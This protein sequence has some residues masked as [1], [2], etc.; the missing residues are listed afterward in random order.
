[1]K[2]DEYSIFFVSIIKLL[3]KF[4]KFNQVI[5][6]MEKNMIVIRDPKTCCFNFDWPKDVDEN[7]KLKLN[8]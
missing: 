7:L 8:L 1:M 3:K 6:I 4:T 2:L 5:N